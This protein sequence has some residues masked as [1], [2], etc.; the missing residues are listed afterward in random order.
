M[1]FAWKVGNGLSPEV[2]T[3]TFSGSG[4]RSNGTSL[5]ILVIA[6]AHI[7]SDDCDRAMLLRL[8]GRAKAENIPVIFLGD[9]FDAMQSREDRRRMQSALREK[10]QGR[11]DYTNA[12]VDDV[13][14]VLDP[15][16]SQVALIGQGNHESA[17]LK[18]LG[19]DL[20]SALLY[21]MKS[22]NPECPAVVGGYTGYIVVRFEDISGTGARSNM[23]KVIKWHHGHSGGV[24][25]GG[26]HAAPRR[27]VYSPDADVIL[28]GH[29]HTEWTRTIARERLTQAGRLVID[30]QLH[31][32]TPS[33]VRG[34]KP[35]GWAQ[36]KG[37]SPL[38]TGA[39]WLRFDVVSD[40]SKKGVGSYRI[41]VDAER[42]R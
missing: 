39:T 18:N 4:L 29:I 31:V 16:S 36:E 11:D 6:D 1:G 14:D 9:Q 28:T 19:M 22:E 5:R 20:S 23:K 38:P 32:Q 12:I 10:Y 15:F 33:L 41:F 26:T 27:A 34:W 35:R 7:D 40:Q 30:E 13:A 21:R 37:F 25:S 24:V 2:F 8:L 42:A 3:L 17:F